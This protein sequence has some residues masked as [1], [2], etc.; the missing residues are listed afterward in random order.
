MLNSPKKPNKNKIDNSSSKKGIYKYEY[1]MKKYLNNK[2]GYKCAFEYQYLGL[3]M[4]NLIFNKDTHLVSVFKDYMI[5]DYNDEFLK[6]YYFTK[7]SSH[8][9]PKFYLLY[10]NYLV[11]FCIPTLTGLRINNLIHNRLYKKAELFYKKNYL[12]KKGESSSE[13]KDFGLCEDSSSSEQDDNEGKNNNNYG[14]KFFTDLIKK[15][16]ENYT[17]FS[18]SFPLNESGS[19]LKKGDS[20]LLI[21]ESKEE[22]LVNIIKGLN[23]E[24]S[25]KKDNYE[26]KNSSKIKKK[27]KEIYL[28]SNDEQSKRKLRIK[29]QNAI[30]SLIRNIYE[31]KVKV[32]LNNYNLGRPTVKLNNP[33]IN[34][35]YINKLKKG[36]IESNNDNQLKLNNNNNSIICKPKNNIHSSYFCIYKPKHKSL[37]DDKNK[38]IIKIHS[39]FRNNVPSRTNYISLENKK[40]NTY[41]SKKNTISQILTKIHTNKSSCSIIKIN[42]LPKG[43]KKCT[44]TRNSSAL[45]ENLTSENNHSINNKEKNSALYINKT[46]IN[47][48]FHNLK[49]INSPPAFTKFMKMVK[50]SN[51]QKK[52]IQS[53]NI[54]INNHI[55]IGLNQM[56]NF[57]SN[58]S[59]NSN[60][61]N[62]TKHRLIINRNKAASLDSNTFKY[63]RMYNHRIINHYRNSSNKKNIFQNIHKT[64]RNSNYLKFG[65]NSGISSKKKVIKININHF[66]TCKTLNKGD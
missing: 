56:K 19:K 59:N 58:I 14:S 38:Q 47:N 64:T 22:S 8:R 63:N 65:K 55:S 49:F 33:F 43:N 48:E 21:T 34:I 25:N 1:Q 23:N 27:K 28:L 54:N 45:L 26:S 2:Y 44:I 3:I 40:S 9:V 66:N 32:L 13:H 30:P 62:K 57:E 6:R 53:I 11:F 36:N 18:T 35:K 39:N 10:K 61:K 50:N 31:E 4:Q 41:Q 5:I 24:D 51:V 15:K 52:G 37:S 42:S 60:F 12:N 17:P 7:E 20:G 16:I 46:K 29:K